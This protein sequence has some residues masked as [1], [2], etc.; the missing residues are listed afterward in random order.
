MAVTHLVAGAPATLVEDLVEVYGQETV[1]SVVISLFSVNVELG[2][3]A[4]Y[5]VADK[6]V[7]AGHTTHWISDLIECIYNYFRRLLTENFE[8]FLVQTA[9]VH[10]CIEVHQ[11]F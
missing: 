10:V 3:I 4:I 5:Y 7:H 11:L 6:V 2:F 8:E 9:L 1:V